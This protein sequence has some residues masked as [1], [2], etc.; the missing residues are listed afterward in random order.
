MVDPRH[1]ED[2]L[3]SFV[4][5]IVRTVTEMH[6]RAFEAPGAARDGVTHGLGRRLGHRRMG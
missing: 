2:E 3:G 6:A 5:S 4:T 1:M